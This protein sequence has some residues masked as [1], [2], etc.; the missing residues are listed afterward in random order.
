MAISDL[1]PFSK[2]LVKK[3]FDPIRKLWLAYSP[4]ELVRQHFICHMLDLG[5]PVEA[6]IVEKKIADIA[7]LFAGYT[8]GYS[9]ERRVDI[10]VLSPEIKPLLLVECK[11]RI[12]LSNCV[13]KQ[14]IGY[15][16]LINAP[17]I[18]LV[19][20]KFIRTYCFEGNNYNFVDYLPSYSEICRVVKL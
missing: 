17:F 19:N 15:N 13:L 14:A 16:S 20:N 4:E 2:K 8:T 18:T 11:G 6:I 3:I 10:L 12:K 9:Y 7:T 5:Y 1:Y